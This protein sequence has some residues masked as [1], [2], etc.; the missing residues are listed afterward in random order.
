MLPPFQTVYDAHRDVVWRFAL[1]VVG[2]QDAPDV[3][4]ETWLAALRAYPDL[5]NA[6]NLR[7]WL[8][9]IAQHKAVDEHRSRSRRPAPAAD[10][11]DLRDDQSGDTTG[12]DQS[13][14]HAVRTL[15]PKQRAAIAH[16]FVADLRYADVAAA[17]GTTP[18]AARRSVHEALQKLRTTWTP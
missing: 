7:G 11:P 16:R 8:L 10:L 14:W 18:A 5:R 2:P 9:T 4:Q 15:P 17:M 12:P 6:D 13:L 1:S 3:F